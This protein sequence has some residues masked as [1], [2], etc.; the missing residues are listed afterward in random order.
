MCQCFLWWKEHYFNKHVYCQMHKL[1]RT[2]YIYIFIYIFFITLITLI[3]TTAY[4]YIYEDSIVVN[5]SLLRF[6]SKAY[7]WQ[8]TNSNLLCSQSTMLVSISN[9]YFSICLTMYYVCSYDPSVIFKIG[10]S[11]KFQKHFTSYHFLYTYIIP[12]HVQSTIILHTNT[13]GF[14]STLH[15]TISSWYHYNNMRSKFAKQSE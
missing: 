2:N 9:I 12:K 11:L 8:D 13:S 4:V 1:R 6:V 5:W 15:K 14:K 10:L 7:I 3:I